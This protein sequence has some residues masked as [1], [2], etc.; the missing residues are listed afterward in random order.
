MLVRTGAGAWVGLEV[1]VQVLLPAPP[2]RGSH[3][4][5]RCRFV[6]LPSAF[7]FLS[8][9]CLYFLFL[10]FGDMQKNRVRE[11]LR[12]KKKKKKERI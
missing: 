4:N 6:A 1:R 12:K 5:L 11:E 7:S 9:P 3:S 10:C 2:P 8:L